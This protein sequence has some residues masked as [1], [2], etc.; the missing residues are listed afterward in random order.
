VENNLRVEA[1]PPIGRSDAAWNLA[2]RLANAKP[3][4]R[5][6]W[7]PN[8]AGKATSPAFLRLANRSSYPLKTTGNAGV[9]R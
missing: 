8:S 7:P 3:A 1:R 9:L 5:S 4:S 6:R 2:N